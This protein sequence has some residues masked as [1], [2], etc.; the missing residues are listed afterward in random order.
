MSTGESK[1][2]MEIVPNKSL[3][4]SL[5]RIEWERRD[6]AV[7]TCQW[8]RPPIPEADVPCQQNLF[9]FKTSRQ[10]EV[11]FPFPPCQ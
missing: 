9:I 6:G 5:S 4:L 1:A 7:G 10:R 2:V 11:R 8:A 3:S